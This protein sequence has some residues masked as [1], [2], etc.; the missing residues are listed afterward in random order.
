M[1]TRI[2]VKNAETGAS[3]DM[4]L[5]QDNT[6]EEI[7]ESAASY[8]EKPP[9]AYVIRKGKQVLR[10]QATISDSGKI[11]DDVLE[12]IPDPEGGH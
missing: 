5:E 9:G 8:W 2:R 1:T 4:D 3:V 7:I 6:V 10:G 11:Q 12:L